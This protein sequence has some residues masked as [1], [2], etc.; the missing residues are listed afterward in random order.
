MAALSL[1]E[2]VFFLKNQP[3]PLGRGCPATAFSPAVAGQVRGQLLCQGK[4]RTQ[5]NRLP[6]QAPGRRRYKSG[7]QSADVHAS[8]IRMESQGLPAGSQCGMEPR[9]RNLPCHLQGKI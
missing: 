2:W 5:S 4:A 7:S 9:R 8:A 1:E 6:R 3:S